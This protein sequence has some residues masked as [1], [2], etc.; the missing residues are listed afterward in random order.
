MPARLSNILLQR[1]FRSQNLSGFTWRWYEICRIKAFITKQNLLFLQIATI[2]A[3]FHQATLACEREDS[4]VSEVIPTIRWTTTASADLRY[5]NSI[6]IFRFLKKK[7]EKIDSNSSYAPLKLA[8]LKQI[9]NYF[10]GGDPRLH[11]GNI[12]LNPAYAI[13]TLLDPRFKTKVWEYSLFFS[14]MMCD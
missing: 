12:S 3:P 5:S 2:L 9:Y 1:I 6:I 10:E 11:F 4:C 7:L 8:L 14:D 13:A